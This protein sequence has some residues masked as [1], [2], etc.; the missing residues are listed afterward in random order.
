MTTQS[1][2]TV[3]LGAQRELRDALLTRGRVLTWPDSR[4]LAAEMLLSLD[5][6]RGCWS[7]AAQWLLA[8][9]AVDRV[10]AGFHTP[11]QRYYVPWAQALA[12]PDVPQMEGLPIDTHE[13][14]IACLWSTGEPIAF[15]A[16]DCNPRLSPNLRLV[17]THAQAASK[18]AT[19]VRY[20]SMPVGLICLDQLGKVRNWS[21]E[22]TLQLKSVAADVVGPILNTARQLAARREAGC[23]KDTPVPA[24]ASQLTESEARVARLVARGLSYNEIARGLGLSHSVVD[25]P[26]RSIRQK[27]GVSSTSRLIRVL[28]EIFPR[29]AG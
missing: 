13:A 15:R 7:M 29:Q 16:I 20:Q 28:A 26:L 12:S 23:S 22:E 25:H 1:Y 4:E 5:D 2:E 27:L 21:E 24:D 10:D 6:A 9:F 14:G 8:R 19:S 3:L 11:A 17:P 18:L